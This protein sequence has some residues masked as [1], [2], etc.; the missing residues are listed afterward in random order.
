M[1]SMNLKT[2]KII[3]REFLVL[4]LSLVIG[5]A[6]F[7]ITY[8]CNSYRQSKS[9]TI[10]K[11]IQYKEFVAD[12]LMR[13]FIVKTEKQEWLHK[14]FSEKINLSDST[15]NSP[16]KLWNKLDEIIEKNSIPTGSN[17]TWKK[18]FVDVLSNTIYNTPDKFQKFVDSNKITLDDKAKYLQARNVVVQIQLLH[19]DKTIQESKIISFESKI[20]ISF[21]AF[22][23]ALMIL[24]GLRY[25]YYSIKWS[26]KT[27]Q[28]E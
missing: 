1:A 7:L 8:F 23:I 4:L 18:E 15:L 13:P 21:W 12:S 24:F 19:D 14:K 20:E 28:K 16:E 26:I 3:A 2:K 27:L 6:A 17:R 25:I 22:C 9:G 5:F 11:Q 10:T